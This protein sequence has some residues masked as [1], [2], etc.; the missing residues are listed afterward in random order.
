MINLWQWPK[1]AWLRRCQ[2]Q[3]QAKGILKDWGRHPQDALPDGIK[4]E[5]F[6]YKIM[7]Q[8]NS[9]SKVCSPEEAISLLTPIAES[10]L[11]NPTLHSRSSHK[12]LLTPTDVKN[13]LNQLKSRRKGILPLRELTEHQ[14]DEQIN[15]RLQQNQD[16]TSQGVTHPLNRL[17][18]STPV[19]ARNGADTDEK[20]TAESGGGGG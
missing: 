5:W 3:T 15:Q 6:G 17:N 14:A 11:L 12:T 8:L 1:K 4:P 2:Q 10:R 9:L 19:N 13:V 16:V 18:A 20:F 7:H